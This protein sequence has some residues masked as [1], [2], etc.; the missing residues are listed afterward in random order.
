MIDPNDTKNM[1]CDGSLTS[2]WDGLSDHLIA[3]FYEV[4][5]KTDQNGKTYWAKVDSYDVVKAPLTEA[6]ME[7]IL[8]WQS[9]F[10]G[11][12]ADKG[13]PTI[14]A[15]LQSGALVP[16]VNPNGKAGQVI[17]NFEG[18]TGITKL[19]S[20]QVFTGMQPVKIQ[21]TAL[22]RAWE[23]PI[24]EVEAPFNQLM[25]WALPVK[26]A[27]D[28]AVMSAFTAVKGFVTGTP[29]DQAAVDLLLP[30]TAPVC[31]AM[32]YKGRTYSPLVIES[33]GHPMNSNVD[34][35]GRYVEMLIPMTL[36]SLTAMDRTDWSNTRDI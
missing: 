11:A 32:K 16:Y 23:K 12:G 20:T 28:G 14:A 29:L 15:M 27:P 7:T 26:L 3:S 25:K 36:C 5:R 35:F 21:V 2:R 24:E 18:R 6:S 10:E 33:I 8:G 22:F 9:P 1:T 34:C 19:N 30:S 17:S 31:I 13:M 4:A